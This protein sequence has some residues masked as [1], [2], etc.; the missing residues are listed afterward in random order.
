MCCDTESHC[1]FFLYLH[2]EAGES[3]RGALSIHSL[4]HCTAVPGPRVS[5][6]MPPP[7]V[8]TTA[9]PRSAALICGLLALGVLSVVLNMSVLLTRVGIGNMH[10]HIAWEPK[11]IDR[12]THAIQSATSSRANYAW[13]IGSAID[14]APH[15]VRGTYLDC[16]SLNNFTIQM[17][18][19]R[20]CMIRND[21]VKTMTCKGIAVPKLSESDFGRNYRL[22]NLLDRWW[23]QQYEGKDFIFNLSHSD[24]KRMVAEAVQLFRKLGR[25]APQ[26]SF[27][28]F[29]LTNPPSRPTTT[30][31]QTPVFW[32]RFSRP[33]S[34]YFRFPWWLYFYDVST[35]AQ[36]EFRQS[37]REALKQ[38]EAQ[39][40]AVVP[41]YASSICV[42]H[43]R[44]GDV[45]EPKYGT[46]S[47]SCMARELY[48]WAILKNLN[49]QEFHVLGGG[50]ILHN[51][52]DQVHIAI[53]QQMLLQFCTTV[54]KFFPNARVYIDVS[55]QPD[56]DFIKMV[57]APMLFTSHGSF[58]MAA[59]LANTGQKASPACSNL[60]FPGLGQRSAGDLVPDWYIYP[61]ELANVS[62]VG[63]PALSW[64]VADASWKSADKSASKTPDKS[65]SKTRQ[66]VQKEQ[67]GKQS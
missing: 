27:G 35:E 14:A 54:Q 42:V 30:V 23:V 34:V 57:S 5:A 22:G 18:S 38:F 40:G 31:A 51:T 3:L 41:V 8:P 26:C 20:L 15:R 44:L 67:R 1:Y 58:A 21:E 50:N 24:R 61:Y 63:R 65:A 32:A 45:L 43:Y 9:H 48:Q 16:W 13:N 33:W 49:I 19:A 56:E 25:Q 53:S 11:Q 6:K 29:L 55:G 60:N 17:Q 52:A 12:V 62:Q 10:L 47:P 46:L 7:S 2:T 28:N 36:I 39:T 66:Y 37:L 59:L 4:Q 64:D